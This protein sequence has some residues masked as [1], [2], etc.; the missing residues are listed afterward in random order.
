VKAIALRGRLK[1]LRWPLA[2]LA[3]LGL[4]PA[5]VLGTT[6]AHWLSVDLPGGRHGPADAYRHSLASAT[7]AYTGSSRWVEWVTAVME[8]GGR[9]DA[10]H[11]MD[12]HNNRL[13]ARIGAGAENWNQMQ[14]AV[15]AAV[16]AGDVEVSDPNRITWLP[17]ERW[18]ERPY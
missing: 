7:V 2:A 8:N 10:A 16:K 5:L 15:L 17:P 14:A 11:A 18:Q 6:Y 12:A 4:Y 1:R 13:G 9:G 3:L